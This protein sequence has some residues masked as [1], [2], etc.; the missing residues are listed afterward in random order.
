MT[1]LE[2]KKMCEENLNGKYIPAECAECQ[3]QPKPHA[4]VECGAINTM[5][6]LVHSEDPVCDDCFQKLQNWQNFWRQGNPPILTCSD[7]ETFGACD[8]CELL[9]N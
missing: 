8:D 5:C 9:K 6:L 1:S 4:C 3:E 7:C 2:L